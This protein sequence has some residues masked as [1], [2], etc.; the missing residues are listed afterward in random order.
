MKTRVKA[1]IATGASVL[2]LGA[3]VGIGT[4]VSAA[5]GSSLVAEKSNLYGCITGPDRALKGTYTI[6]QNF[7]NAGGCQKTVGGFPVTVGD[8][9]VPVP[10]MPTPTPTPTT[11]T[12][13][14][15]QTTPAPTPT[16]TTPPPTTAACVNSVYS[17]NSSTAQCN[18]AAYGPNIVGAQANNH[19]WVSQ[20]VWNPVA[21]GTQKLTAFSPSSWNIVANV[22]A[23]HNSDGGIVSYPD[24]GFWMGNNTGTTPVS[25]FTSVTSSWDVTL[26]TD[27]NVTA[28]WAAYDLWFNNWADEVMIRT[29]VVA[30][31]AYDSGT[32]VA[33]A[34]FGGIPW[35]MQRFGAERVWTPGADD[36]HKIN[37]AKGSVDVQAM[38][39]WMQGHGQ[40]SPTSVWTAASFG[41]EVARTNSTNQ[42][43]T[44]NNFTWN[45]Q[46]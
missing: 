20:N 25:S 13:T 23:S 38:L 45:A 3:G 21:G 39:T 36:A 35:H 31:T 26:P 4:A 34:T 33:T 46:Q 42:T 41:F 12:P 40:L 32:P 29:D 37:I 9:P 30:P 2:L 16:P 18:F 1:A 24:T 28:G 27:P 15:T 44:V 17:N 14:P 10:T 7:I 6:E 5:T 22:P 43:F 19:P 11:P 8:Q